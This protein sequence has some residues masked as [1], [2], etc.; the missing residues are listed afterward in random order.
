MR[1]RSGPPKNKRQLTV[2]YVSRYPDY[3]HIPAL[4]IKGQWQEAVRFAAS[5]KV[6]SWVMEKRIVLTSVETAPY[7]KEAMRHVENLSA[8]KQKQVREFIGVI[9]EKRVRG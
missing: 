2:S 9:A 3:S 1:S 4:T 8:K 6:E 7:L 5:T